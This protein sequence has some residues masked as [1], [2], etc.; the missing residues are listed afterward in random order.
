MS[1]AEKQF[2]ERSAKRIEARHKREE[3]SK[4]STTYV[5]PRNPGKYKSHGWLLQMDETSIS[6]ASMSFEVGVVCRFCGREEEFH[7]EGMSDTLIILL[8]IFG[9]T[10][11]LLP[12]KESTEK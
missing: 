2:A 12:V 5:C 10:F 9:A 4:G 8:L 6:N 11:L 7:G 1:L 3:L